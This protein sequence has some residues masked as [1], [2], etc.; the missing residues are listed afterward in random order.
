MVA[1][2][3][4]KKNVKKPW[5]IA[6]LGKTATGK[7]DLAV[8]LAKKWDGEVISAD[9]RQIYRGLDL[10]TGKIT[11][12]EMKG[13]PHHLLDIADSKKQFSVSEYKNLADKTIGEIISRGKLPII[14][15]GTGLYIDAVLKN[16]VV[17]EVPPN[18]KLRKELEKKTVPQLFVILKKLD[19]RRAKE[20]D[21]NNPRRL[22]RAIEIATALGSIPLLEVS[23]PKFNVLKTI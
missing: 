1:L 4:M 18:K 17:P 15:G 20:I 9:S 8:L 19:S 3:L 14:C 2:G 6:I 10:G 22:I 5:I 23:P 16:I 13:I 11:K 21:A 7:S 12:R